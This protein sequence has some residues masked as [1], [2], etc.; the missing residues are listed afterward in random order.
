MQSTTPVPADQGV[1]SGQS[2]RVIVQVDK[3]F[4]LPGQRLEGLVQLNLKHPTKIRSLEISFQGTENVHFTTKHGKYSTTYKAT[5]PMVS[6]GIKLSGQTTLPAGTTNFPFAFDIPPDALPSYLGKAAKVTWM[7]SAKAD[8][9]WSGDLKQD[10]YPV[11]VNPFP[12]PAVTVAFENPEVSPKIR[13]ELSSNVYQPG[14]T[15]EGK[16]TLLEES[17]LRAVRLQLFLL[18]QAA[19]QGKVVGTTSGSSVENMQIGEKFEWPRDNLLAAREVPFRIPLSPQ[20]PCSYTGKYSSTEWYLYATLDIPHHGDI[21]LDASF[22]VAMKTLPVAVIQPEGPVSPRAETPPSTPAQVVVPQ[23][24]DPQESQ[25]P[26]IIEILADGSAKDVVSV[27][28]ELEK[29]GGI[30]DINQVRGLCEKLVQQG[31][32]ERVGEG[33]F[34]AQY[35]LRTVAAAQSASP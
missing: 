15:V 26:M 20:T 10:V 8:V 17:N 28:N 24:T 27:N 11:I 16:L 1:S 21:L 9:P 13:L 34:F 19:G 31:R 35:R 14:E 12:R 32:L 6:T 22:G 25:V 4:Y 23:E 2:P 3:P 5:N 30:V 29:R 18:E 7:L 33:E